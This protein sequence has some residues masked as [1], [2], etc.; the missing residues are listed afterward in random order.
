MWLGFGIAAAISILNLLNS[1][2]PAVPYLPVKRQNIHQYFTGRP[3]NAMGG[4]RLSFYPFAIGISF[5]IPLDLL[6][7]VGCS[8]GCTNLS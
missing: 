1:I 3:W 8:I 5:L 2:Y 7:R 6:F 4:V